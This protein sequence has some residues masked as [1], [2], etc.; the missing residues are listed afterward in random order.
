MKAENNLGYLL[1]KAAKIT[2]GELNNRLSEVGITAPQYAVLKDLW[3]TNAEHETT[4]AFVAERLHSDRP[5]ISGIIDRLEKQG[6]IYRRNNPEDRRSLIV[7]LTEV[8]KEQMKVFE[9]MSNDTIAK[10]LDGFADNEISEL[11]S[12]LKRIINNFI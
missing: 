12:Y 3:I 11:K 1:N 6:F 5:T 9:E 10:A 8:A 2:R 7:G 4:P